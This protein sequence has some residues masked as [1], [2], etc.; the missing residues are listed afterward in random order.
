MSAITDQLSSLH[1]DV[2]RTVESVA[3]QKK[4]QKLAELQEAMSQSKFWDDPKSAGATSQLAAELQREVDEWTKLDKEVSDALDLAK[5]ADTE[6]DHH[7]LEELGQQAEQMMS[8]FRQLE[9]TMLL[10]GKY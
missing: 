8:K 7:V 6:E 9:L 1:V 4:R 10:N 3:V 2:Q 5:H